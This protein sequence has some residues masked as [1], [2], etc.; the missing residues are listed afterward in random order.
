MPCVVCCAVWR[1]RL[2]STLRVYPSPEHISLAAGRRPKVSCSKCLAH[3]MGQYWRLLNIDQKAILYFTGNK[4]GEIM[5]WIDPA[6]LVWLLVKPRKHPPYDRT[7]EPGYSTDPGDLGALNIPVHILALVFEQFGPN[8]VSAIISLSLTNTYLREIGQKRLDQIMTS[9]HGP[10]M[11]QRLICVGDYVDGDD[12]PADIFVDEEEEKTLMGNY[13]N[14]RAKIYTAFQNGY[15]Y[16]DKKVKEIW[17][18]RYRPSYDICLSRKERRMMQ[19]MVKPDYSWDGRPET[20]WILCNGSTGEYVRASA[21]AELTGT[22]CDGPFT[23]NYLS[24]GHVL[25]T[26]ICWSGDTDAAMMY[27]GPITRGPW[28]GHDFGITTVD[29]LGQDPW[30]D[31]TEKI[32]KQV[33]EIWRCD[34]PEILAEHLRGSDDESDQGSDAAHDRSD[35]KKDTADDESVQ[36]G[37]NKSGKKSDDINDA[38]DRKL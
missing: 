23:S 38:D 36:S 14:G 31:S 29:N 18:L 12:L 16:D 20:E 22:Q 28:A 26:Q 3:P 37:L 1:Q 24:L 17:Y 7:S 21:V 25:L 8:D 13:N 6:R 2:R 27:E 10:W 33:L 4:L 34:N 32:V 30:K 15:Y 5:F 9:S 19:A 11:W 35:N